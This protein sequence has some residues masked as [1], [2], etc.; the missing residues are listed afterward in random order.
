MTASSCSTTLVLIPLVFFLFFYY[1]FPINKYDI[2]N[3]RTTFFSSS[4]LPLVQLNITQ[5]SPPS[6]PINVFKDGNITFVNNAVSDPVDVLDNGFLSPSFNITTFNTNTNTNTTTTNT[7]NIIR[8]RTSLDRIEEGLA[9]ARAAIQEAVRS[10]N[11]TSP[12]DEDFVPRGS[13]YRNPYAFHQSHIEM[14]KRFKIWT[15]KEGEPPLAHDGP[16]NN[17]YSTEGQFIDEMDSGKNRFEARHP[18][19]AYA[20]FLPFSVVNVVRFIYKPV[21]NFSRER[22]QRVVKDYISVVSDKYPYWN[23]SNGADHFMVSCHDWAPGVSAAEPEFFKHLIRVLC[24]ANTSEG[25][26]P[27]R[28]VSLPEIYLP[29]GKLGPPHLNQDPLKR[30]ILAFFAG[31]A[32]GHIRKV[33]LNHW[34]AKDNEVQVH[35]YLP[36]GQNYNKLMS[37]SKYCLCP[38]GY[39]V[40]SPRVVEAIYA[41]CVPVL[42]S[43]SYVLPFSDVLDWTQISVQIPLEKIP[44]IK[45]ILKEI[46]TEKYLKLQKKVRRVQ[47]H[48][49]LNR[50]AQRFDVMHM[51]LHSVW[52]RRLNVRLSAL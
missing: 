24:N 45:N 25:F 12:K 5:A 47:R 51:V 52:L 8:E 17:I 34:K 16:L 10:R 6:N 35:E 9:R 44:E 18:D 19:E 20:F 30:S 14:E 23:R 32:H 22:L 15:Y 11:Y 37:E 39:E 26:Q 50:P 27:G 48:F 36:K 13:I 42:I 46:P 7:T 40:A 28:D 41:G 4:S 31:G 3:T 29:F 33:L 49:V 38:S 1:L 43:E 21:T 2:N